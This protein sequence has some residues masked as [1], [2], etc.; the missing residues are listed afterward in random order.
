MP[1]DASRTTKAMVRFICPTRSEGL[2]LEADS[3]PRKLDVDPSANRGSR[4][5]NRNY[6]RS[7]WPATAQV[8]LDCKRAGRLIR[9]SRMIALYLI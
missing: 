3:S 8:Y 1:S 5:V 6:V 7:K 2:E 4:V 9:S